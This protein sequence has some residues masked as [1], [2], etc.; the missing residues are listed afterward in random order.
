VIPWA[1]VVVLLVALPVIVALI[2]A[3]TASTRAELSLHPD[4]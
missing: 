1:P 4:R 3:V 2:A